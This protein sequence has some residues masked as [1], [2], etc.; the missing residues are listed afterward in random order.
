MLGQQET[1]GRYLAIGLVIVIERSN[2]HA[3]FA[4]ARELSDLDGRL[5]VAG[6]QQ[7]VF[8]LCGFLANA[9]DFFED[10]VGFGDLFFTWVFC[11][12]TG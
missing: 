7:L 5:R 11:T 8:G 2:R 10:S 6:N 4:V 9:F 3:T 12:R 1:H